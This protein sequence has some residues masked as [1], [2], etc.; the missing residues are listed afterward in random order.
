MPRPAAA[1]PPRASSATPPIAP[2]GPYTPSRIP[3]V[4]SAVNA[5]ICTSMSKFASPGTIA[6]NVVEALGR[7]LPR[8]R[9]AGDIST[10]ASIK[11]GDHFASIDEAITAFRVLHAQAAGRNLRRPSSS[12]TDS[13]AKGAKGGKAILVCDSPADVCPQRIVIKE[14]PDGSATVL[15]I[16]EEH[17]QCVA[18]ASLPARVMAQDPLI[19]SAVLSS[20]GGVSSGTLTALLTSGRIASTATPHRISRLKQQV[21]KDHMAKTLAYFSLLPEFGARLVSANKDGVFVLRTKG[22]VTGSNF[23]VPRSRTWEWYQGALRAL[24]SAA[25]GS[26]FG[27]QE[28]VSVWVLVPHAREVFLACTPVVAMDFCHLSGDRNVKVSLV[29]KLAGY[30]HDIAVMFFNTDLSQED[31]DAGFRNLPH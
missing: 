27:G 5:I 1:T 14:R 28:F 9:A 3:E 31:F 4:L 23:G 10:L 19:R 21:V 12:R 24:D 22:N 8:T 15:E 29:A 17:G 2:S 20:R 18:A 13:R 26:E 30:A 25:P 11:R 16:I 6:T 7:T